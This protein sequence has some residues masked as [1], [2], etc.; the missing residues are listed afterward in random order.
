MQ[1][2]GAG[3]DGTGGGGACCRR[4]SSGIAAVEIDVSPYRRLTRSAVSLQHP[5]TS[6]AHVDLDDDD[7]DDDVSINGCVGSVKVDTR[8]A[9][10]RMGGWVG[11]AS[12]WCGHEEDGVTDCEDDYDSLPSA[13][14]HE[15]PI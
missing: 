11:S 7:D 15:T 1:R 3:D 12:G 13:L 4:T 14:C 5:R 10:L 6:A 9:G 2:R 8:A